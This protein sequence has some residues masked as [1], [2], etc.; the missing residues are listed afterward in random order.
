MTQNPF[1]QPEALWAITIDVQAGMTELVESAFS[2]FDLAVSSFEVD[3]RAG[4]WKTEILC[5]QEPDTDAIQTRLDRL[6]SA[7]DTPCFSWTFAPV[8]QQDWL[9]QV[10][11]QFPPLRAGRFFVHGTHV[12]QPP[13]AGSV[14]LLVDAGAAFGS[15]EHATTY[16]CLIAIEQLARSGRKFRNMLDMGC[17]SGILAMAMTKCWHRS[18]LAVDVDPVAIRVTNENFARNEVSRWASGICADG[19]RD[20]RVMQTAPY[21]LIAANILARPLVQ[22]APKLAQCLAPG[23]VAILSGLLGS[24]ERYVLCA[25][26][27]QG[28]RLVRRIALNGWHSL[29]ISA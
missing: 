3:E 17:G 7:L 24:Q 1:R 8:P 16:G 23:G 20:R 18:V 22:F 15:G 2:D 12:T 29:I 21:D 13:P 5:E 14:P 19:Y 25:H 6:A 10:A 11:S 27:M 9:A 26:E 28:L 4:L